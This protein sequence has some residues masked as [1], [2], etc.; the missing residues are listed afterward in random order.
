MEKRK[1]SQRFSQSFPGHSS[2]SASYLLIRIQ[3]F[4]FA[5]EVTSQI[6]LTLR[7]NVLDLK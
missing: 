1:A 6:V 2:V 4:L 3:R 7:H 5:Q